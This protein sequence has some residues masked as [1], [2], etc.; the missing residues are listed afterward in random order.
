MM[1]QQ[2]APLKPLISVIVPI[3]NVEKYVRKCLESLKNQSLKQI[4]VICIDDGSTDA[5]G[6]I[7]DEYE[8]DDWP[9]IKVIHT[10]NRGLSAARNRGID[11]ARSEWLMFVD[12]D[13]WVDREFCEIPY[14][15]AVRENADIVAF[16]SYRVVH[17]R[18]KKPKDADRPVGVVDEMTAYDYVDGPAWN[19]LYKKELFEDIRYPEG[20]VYE[21]VS[22]THKLIHKAA[23]IYVFNDSL[24]YHVKREGSITQ[25]HTAANKRD[26]FVAGI[27]R[28]EDLAS[29]GYPAERVS[30]CGPAIGFLSAS[31][32]S[33]DPLYLK[34]VEMVDLVQGCPKGLTLKQK[35]GLTVWRVNRPLFYFICRGLGRAK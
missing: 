24:Y 8:S 13:D 10:K 12:S 19:K 9:V 30:I 6:R 7:A 18:V 28:Q 25:T 5:S 22:T 4:E 15:T 31:T 14:R 1:N 34:A 17:G 33:D 2:T 20:H 29:Y 16:Q 3:Y 32:P 21:D 35:M 23:R 11:E 26:G 27:E